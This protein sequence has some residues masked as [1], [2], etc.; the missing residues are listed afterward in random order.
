MKKSGLVLAALLLPASLTPAFAQSRVD[1]TQGNLQMTG[2][3]QDALRS[4]IA[5]CWN[6]PIR[7]PKPEELVVDFDLLLNSDGSVA[8]PP[9]LV[10][11]SAVRAA[12][13]R[14]TRAAADAARRAIYAC[15]PFKLPADRY[16]QWREISPLHFD[17][18]AMMGQ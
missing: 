1:A 18:R 14:Y 2:D 11:Q 8:R 3:I 17:P 13:D 9:Q 7:A 12:G 5:Q 16:S 10:G 4:Q 15:A 6:P